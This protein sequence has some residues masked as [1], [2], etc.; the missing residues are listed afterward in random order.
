MAKIER[1][2]LVAYSA[3]QMFSLV[4]DIE[5]YPQFMAGCTG[6]EVLARGDGWLE[7]RLDLSRAGF[8]QSFTTRNTLKPPHSMDLQLVAGPF[9]AFKGR[10]QFDALSESACKITF[11]LEYEFANK[12]LALAA[13]KIFE[14]VASEQVSTLCERARQVFV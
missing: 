12:L 1:T 4:N 10:W 3:E 13:G 6:A 14:Q 11:S 2:A 5:S 8:K 9:S 7:A